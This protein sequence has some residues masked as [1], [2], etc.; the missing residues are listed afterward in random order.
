MILNQVEAGRLA[1]SLQ[2][3][4][5]EV[6]AAVVYGWL[7]L[8]CAA[9]GTPG[10]LYVTSEDISSTFGWGL[11]YAHLQLLCLEKKGLLVL[12]PGSLYLP[13]YLRPPADAEQARVWAHHVWELQHKGHAEAAAA[14]D[15]KILT[16]CTGARSL[17][18][19]Y[20][21]ARNP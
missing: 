16:C 7:W 19:A 8:S 15:E 17:R 21:L 4:G 1:R 3:M 5:G 12:L 14:L 2:N 10:I 11:A 6:T 9:A 13:E 18:R 20:E